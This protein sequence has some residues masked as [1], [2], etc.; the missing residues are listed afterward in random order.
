MYI[1]TGCTSHCVLRVF[2]LYSGI[3]R[4]VYSTIPKRAYD[5][6]FRNAI[7]RRD[8]KSRNADDD[9]GSDTGR[10]YSSQP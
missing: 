10:C 9:Y 8:I 6:S 2:K 5:E 4:L 3:G 7:P 1:G